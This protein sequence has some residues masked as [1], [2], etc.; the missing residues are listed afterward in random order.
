MHPARGAMNHN[1]PRVAREAAQWLVRLQAG[2]ADGGALARWRAADPHHE[3]AWQRAEAVLHTLG[4]AHGPL[5]AQALRASGGAGR[6]AATRL[7]AALIIAGPAGWAAWRLA[8]W[9]AWTAAERTATGERRWLDLPDGGRL[10]LDTASAADVAYT[11]Q[12]RRVVLH[13]GALWV[14]TARD[15]AA[16]PFLVQAPQGTARALGTRFS[17]R[18]AGE[19]TRVAV[20]E[21]AVELRPARGGAPVH[22]SAGMQATLTAGAAGPTSARDAL[23]DGWT[24]GV[25]YA[26]RMPLGE[27]TAELARYRPGLLRCAPEV[28]ALPVSGAFQLA[29]TDAALAALAA[30]LPVRIELRT[31][32][33]VMIGPG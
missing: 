13:T 9:A 10:L 24:E 19:A 32:W 23:A 28:A 6:R 22:V 5:G 7:L 33:W 30:S 4:R 26:E 18:I 8:P 16:R 1:D 11:A 27:F 31:R 17:V 2:E 15:A 14:Q 29:D 3:A 21:G 25:L 20:A 12:A